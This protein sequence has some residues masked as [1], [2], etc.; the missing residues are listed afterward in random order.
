MQKKKF[1]VLFHF[2]PASCSFPSATAAAP[3]TRKTPYRIFFLKII[4]VA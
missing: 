1:N 3:G 2:R 4:P